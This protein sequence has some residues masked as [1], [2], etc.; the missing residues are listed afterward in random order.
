MLGYCPSGQSPSPENYIEIQSI[1]RRQARVPERGPSDGLAGPG[2][3]AAAGSIKAARK[4]QN[5]EH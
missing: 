3:P 2:R 1:D 5:G 4:R